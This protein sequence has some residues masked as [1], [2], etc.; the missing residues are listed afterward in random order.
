MSGVLAVEGEDRAAGEDSTQM[1]VGP[2]VTK[3][4][5]DHWPGNG[6]DQP[7]Q[8]V[9]AIALGLHAAYETVETT[10]PD[11]QLAGSTAKPLSPFS[12]GIAGLRGIVCRPAVAHRGTTAQVSGTSVAMI[13]RHYGHL[14]G[15]IAAAALARLAI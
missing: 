4:Q 6:A 11:L 15:E 5:F 7:G 1:V 3:A 8:H 13:E 12:K 9:E 2:A 10:H 14:R